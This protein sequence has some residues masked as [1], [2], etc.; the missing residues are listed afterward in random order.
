MKT[1]ILTIIF[2][3]GVLLAICGVGYGWNNQPPVAVLQNN[4][5]AV[6]DRAVWFYGYGSYDPTQGGYITKYEWDFHYTGD[7]S[8]EYTETATNAPDGAFDGVARYDGYSSSGPLLNTVRLKVTDNGNPARTAWA[9]ITVQVYIRNSSTRIYVDEEAAGPTH[10]GTSWATAYK[11][12]QVALGEADADGKNEIWVAEGTYRPDLSDPGEQS[13]YFGL[14]AD[15][16]VYGG[17]DP[18]IG[19]DSWEERDWVN[20]KT[21]LSGDINVQGVPGDNSRNV[22]YSEAD[23]VL[24]GF[25]I[26]GGNSNS[27]GSGIKSTG[28]FTLSNCVIYDNQAN[29]GGGLGLLNYNCSVITN[30]VFSVNTASNDGGAISVFFG[31][32]YPTLINCLFTGNTAENGGAI[33]NDRSDPILIN[34][35]FNGNSAVSNGKDMYNKDSNPKLTNCI[36]WEDVNPVFNDI[37]SS[38][39]YNYCDVKGSGGSSSWVLSYGT[40]GGGNI[41]IDPEFVKDGIP[42]TDENGADDKF[43]TNDDGLRLAQDSPCIDAGDNDAISEL[44]DIAGNDRI[45]NNATVDMGAYEFWDYDI[46]YVDKMATAGK[47]NGTTWANAFIEIQDAITVAADNDEIWVADGTYVLTSDMDIDEAI[48]FY[49]GFASGETQRSQRNW[50]TNT[51]TVDGDNVEFIRCFDILDNCITIDGFTIINGDSSGIR[52]SDGSTIITN[53]TFTGNKDGISCEYSSSPTINNCTFSGNGELVA[54]VL[55][56]GGGISISDSSSPTISDCEFSQNISSGINCS[57]S[58]TSASI[59]NCVFSGNTSN[60]GGGISCGSS[61]TISDCTFSGNNV[62]WNGS[63]GGIYCGSSSPTIEDCIFTGNT[64]E[65]YGGA[66]ACISPS[67]SSS[68]SP[69]IERCVFSLNIAGRDGG[70]LYGWFSEPTLINCLFIDNKADNGGGIAT[71]ASDET[72][73]INCTFYRNASLGISRGG[74]AVY[75][76]AISGGRCYTTLTNCILWGNTAVNDGHEVCCDGDSSIYK[77]IVTLEY[78]DIQNTTGWMYEVNSYSEVRY[79]PSSFYHNIYDDPVFVNIGF[80]KGADNEWATGDDGFMIQ[81]TSQCKDS[82]DDVTGS[83]SEDITGNNRKIGIKVDRGAYEY[84]PN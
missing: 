68:S 4:P 15:V 20:N 39:T 45:F 3:L 49:G 33:Y 46:I 25:T 71:R 43:M 76:E 80:P 42:G 55:R 19:H 65:K 78:C 56:F 22:V 60:K 61:I 14:V 7:F 32:N 84:D 6:T 50:E 47:D 36:L 66:I 74:G 72:I 35:T 77:A 41:D 70:G 62:D 52:C 18:S 73:A 5:N 24:D 40:N 63:G 37:S 10:D 26:T 27:F 23:S 13:L 75:A 29:S 1:R 53:C 79:E 16:G 12:L 81:S 31:D 69:K 11:D 54:G 58:S 38:P 30:C 59:S 67:S 64:A 28:S 34:C 21:I 82:G 48:S 57:T 51:T 83:I 44:K 2:V 9:S 17:F 8:A